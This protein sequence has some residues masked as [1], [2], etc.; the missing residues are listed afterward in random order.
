MNKFITIAGA[1]LPYVLLIALGAWLTYGFMSQKQEISNLKWDLATMENRATSAEYNLE[2]E[3][4]WQAKQREWRTEL[5][6][7]F[8]DLDGKLATYTKQLETIKDARIKSGTNN[9]LSEPVTRV[10]KDFTNTER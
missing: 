9:A 4:K 2:Q 10:L 8:L 3:K 7:L 5:D 6:A 1:L